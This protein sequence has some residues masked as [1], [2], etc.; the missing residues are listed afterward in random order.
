MS[1][2]ARAEL[3]AVPWCGARVVRRLEAI[4]VR[5]LADLRGRDPYELME[6]V[7]AAAGRAIWRPPMAILALTNLIAAADGRELSAGAEEG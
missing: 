7:N 6:R 1:P 4:G 3:L 2:Q 5:C